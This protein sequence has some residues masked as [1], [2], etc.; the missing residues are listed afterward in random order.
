MRVMR[1]N[2]IEIRQSDRADA[3]LFVD[4]LATDQIPREYEEDRDGVTATFH[5]MG[6]SQH[7]PDGCQKSHH[8][9][10]GA[11]GKGNA[12]WIPG[13]AGGMPRI[14]RGGIRNLLGFRCLTVCIHDYLRRRLARA[15]SNP[16]FV[17]STM[18]SLTT[19]A[20]FWLARSWE[21]EK[22]A[23]RRPFSCTELQKSGMAILFREYRP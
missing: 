4:E 12:M 7:D 15:A 14:P 2:E 13:R 5:G 10:H 11:I 20:G 3:M 6:V 23:G 16:S 22:C 9:E 1:L 17:R 8:V 18:R 19:T 21:P